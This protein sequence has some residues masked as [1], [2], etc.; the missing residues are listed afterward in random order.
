MPFRMEDIINSYKI[1]D[2]EPDKRD[3]LRR[4]RWMEG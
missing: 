2:A 4:K 1:S 3:H